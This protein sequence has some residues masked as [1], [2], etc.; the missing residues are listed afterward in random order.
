[1]RLKGSVDAHHEEIEEALGPHNSKQLKRS[2]ERLIEKS[3]LH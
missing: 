1:M 3:Q 2:L